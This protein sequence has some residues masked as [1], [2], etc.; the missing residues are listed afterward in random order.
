MKAACGFCVL[1]LATATSLAAGRV[2]VVTN[3]AAP[4]KSDTK[5]ADI[6]VPKPGAVRRLELANAFNKP[7]PTTISDLRLMQRHV[8]ALIK[9]LEPSV[10]AVE[11][12]QASGSGV[13]I[14]AD[15]IV[16]TAGHVAGKPNRDVRF[17]FPDGKTARGKTLGA[18]SESDAGLMQ[19]TDRG[20]WPHVEVGE[21]GQTRV[22]DWVLAMGHPGGFDLQ[23]SL[24][25]RLGR[26]IRLDAGALQSDCTIS[27]GDSGGPLFDMYGR[28]IGIHSFISGSMTE[29]FH[30]PITKFFEGWDRLVKGESGSDSMAR[31]RAYVGANSVDDAKGCRVDAVE[32]DGPA[33]KAGLKVGDLVLKV[34]DREIRAAAT[35][36]RWVSEAEP[37]ETLTL[38]I[39]RA[40]KKMTLAVK[41]EARPRRT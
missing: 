20:P 14:S 24:V 6:P 18:D 25:V 13:I 4:A 2:T 33:F 30:V 34:N 29:N 36:R 41:V 38:E 1:V 11:I 37:G 39:Q 31:S 35:F 23:R 7:A 5:P 17:T 21:L 10:V 32:K 40:E 9:R 27:G 28:V 19:I 26:L 3:S 16:L 8:E 12:G 22:G 15:G